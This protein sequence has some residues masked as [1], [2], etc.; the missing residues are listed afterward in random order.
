M[1]H[2]RPKYKFIGLVYDSQKGWV[3]AYSHEANTIED[4]LTP[5]AI[6]HIWVT[7]NQCSCGTYD[8]YMTSGGYPIAFS[9]LTFPHEENE[10]VNEKIDEALCIYEEKTLP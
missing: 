6:A 3:V 2:P 10:L 1:C 9:V 4:L 5:E 7:E 8:Y